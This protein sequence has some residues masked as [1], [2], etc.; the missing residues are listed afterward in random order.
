MTNQ[1]YERARGM[2]ALTRRGMAEA[3]GIDV[4]TE[5]A[6]GRGGRGV[7]RHIALAIT[8]LVHGLPA[9]GSTS[10]NSRFPSNDR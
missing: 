6:Y 5:R 4:K 3:L 9:W 7:P 10:L 2:L 1:D 8:A